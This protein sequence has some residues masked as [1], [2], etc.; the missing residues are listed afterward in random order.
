[1][2]FLVIIQNDITPT[3]YS[4]QTYDAALSAFH[5]EMGYRHESRTSTACSLMD[6]HGIVLR[7][8][9]WTAS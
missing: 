9:V 6:N 3:I 5:Q 8:E 7:N 2:Y 4:Y 1:M